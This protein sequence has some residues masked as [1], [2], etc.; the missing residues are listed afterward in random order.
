MYSYNVIINNTWN[1]QIKQ[2]VF[3]C[4]EELGQL[5]QKLI[6]DVPTL[7][8]GPAGSESPTVDMKDVWKI[9]GSP[10]ESFLPG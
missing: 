10:L 7:K 3:D 2:K 8:F 4:L 6:R 1:Q 5:Q 9:A